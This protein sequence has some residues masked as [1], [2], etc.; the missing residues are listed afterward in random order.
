MNKKSTLRSVANDYLTHPKKSKGI[1]LIALIVTI[2][3]LIIL[4]GIAISMLTGNNNI[5]SSATEAREETR[6][7]TAKEIMTLKITGIETKSYSEKMR[8]PTLKE[9]A[10]ALCEDDDIKYVERVSQGIGKNNL[11][12]KITTEDTHF[13]TKLKEYPYEFEINSN[14]K[15]ASING[16]EGEDDIS[17]G[18][19]Q[20]TP[21]Q[22]NIIWDLVDITDNGTKGV[23]EIETNEIFIGWNLSYILNDDDEVEIEQKTKERINVVRND[24]IVVKYTKI[25]EDDEVT[26]DINITDLNKGY[27]LIYNANEGTGA[28]ASET[29]YVDEESYTFT[30]SS[31]IPVNSK[32]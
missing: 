11:E 24:H 25:G 21:T 2:I 16:V 13:Y 15:I 18:T 26:K 22:D 28:P 14:L 1:T 20:I 10:D 23:L 9:V 8:M 7:A 17:G 19:E 31:T 30:I 5:L 4:A 32:F 27:T 3:V 6:R 29:Q 12:K